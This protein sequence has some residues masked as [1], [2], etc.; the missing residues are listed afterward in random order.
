MH[1]ASV[2]QAAIGARTPLSLGQRGIAEVAQSSIIL[3]SL[4]SPR[5]QDARGKPKD[6]SEP[7]HE[8]VHCRFVR[9][10]ARSFAELHKIRR[11]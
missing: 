4:C 2:P 1:D 6:P 3:P 10:R 9:L 8:D 11:G 7:Q 5:L